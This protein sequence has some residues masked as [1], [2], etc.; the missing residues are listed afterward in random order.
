M[1]APKEVL[2]KF[3][4]AFNEAD[5]DAII[6]LYDENAVNHQ[7]ANEPIV[8]KAAIKEMFIKEFA[9]AKMICIVENIFEDAQWAIME[10]RDPLGLRGC[11][12]FQVVNN[13]IIFQRGYWDK[14]SFLK[15]HNL[16]LE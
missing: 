16:P 3:I 8:G 5:V 4:D 12:F 1:S 2:K 7:V 10:W 14:L 15:Q 11:G 9:Q 13:K 6:E